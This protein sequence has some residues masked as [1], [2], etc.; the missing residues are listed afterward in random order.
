MQRESPSCPKT[1]SWH[2]ASMEKPKQ[3]PSS[4]SSQHP[5][6]FQGQPIPPK[7]NNSK[8]IKMHDTFFL[9]FSSIPATI[10]AARYYIDYQAHFKSKYTVSATTFTLCYSSYATNNATIC[11][12]RVTL[13]Y[14]MYIQYHHFLSSMSAA[15]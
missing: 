3:L 14:C 10:D 11:Y 15:L 2:A 5:G 4:S 12:G 7:G 1:S 8:A 9:L 13:I 6:P